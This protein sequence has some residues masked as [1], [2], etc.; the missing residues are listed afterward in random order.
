MKT[1]IVITRK[2][3]A[4]DKRN[5]ITFSFDNMESARLFIAKFNFENRI[6][7]IL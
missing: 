5:F 6:I 1:Q 2:Q 7:D 4:T 3:T